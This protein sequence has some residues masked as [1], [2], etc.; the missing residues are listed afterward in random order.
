MKEMF[1]SNDPTQ[2]M[3]DIKDHIYER[4]T[5][6]RGLL[7]QYE[8]NG[9]SLTAHE[10]GYAQGVREELRYLERLLDIAERS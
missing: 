3:H 5:L 8:E 4:M 10:L 7:K 9:S 2:A 6:T 1:F